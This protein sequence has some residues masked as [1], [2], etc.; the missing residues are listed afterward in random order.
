[1]I[2]TNPTTQKTKDIK[3]SLKQ[4]FDNIRSGNFRFYLMGMVNQYKMKR[5]K[6]ILFISLF[7]M[8]CYKCRNISYNELFTVLGRNKNISSTSKHTFFLN[9]IWRL[10]AKKGQKLP[11]PKK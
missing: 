4:F 1:M 6:K 10:E 3:G 5:P 8:I 11:C 7:E 9:K 2:H